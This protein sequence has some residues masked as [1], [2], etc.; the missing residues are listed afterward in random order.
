MLAT[1][2]MDRRVEEIRLEIVRP[3]RLVEREGAIQRLVERDPR[4]PA[5]NCA[6]LIMAGVVVTDVDLAALLWIV[7]DHQVAGA[8][9]AD[10]QLG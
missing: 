3:M 6:E 4:A 9:K 8:M 10:H 5:R 7:L 1:E 2:S